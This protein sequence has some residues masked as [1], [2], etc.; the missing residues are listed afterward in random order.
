VPQRFEH[1]LGG[2]ELLPI[3]VGS[4]LRRVAGSLK[5]CRKTR[6]IAEPQD[7]AARAETTLDSMYEAELWRIKGELLLL[8]GNGEATARD[9]FER[10]GAIAAA[11]GAVALVRRAAES[12]ARV[13]R[14]ASLAR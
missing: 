8:G 6:E 5:H 9:C 1:S 3:A 10:A 14:G 7:E 2:S 4:M 12:R 13:D 11:Q